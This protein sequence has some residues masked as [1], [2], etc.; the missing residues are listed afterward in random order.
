MQLLGDDRPVAV[1]V[2]RF[3]RF[4]HDIDG[5]VAHRF[6]RLA[7]RGQRRRGKPGDG[8]VIKASH[9]AIFWHANPGLGQRA[10]G[11]ERGD[12]VESQD[13]R[14]LLLVPEEFFR[15]AEAVLET[16]IGIEDVW[17]LEL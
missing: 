1:F 12:V 10:D 15:Q 8:D 16:G 6:Q 9:R 4:H 5:N 17:E 2:A 11:A 3:D 13:R 14:K 7:H